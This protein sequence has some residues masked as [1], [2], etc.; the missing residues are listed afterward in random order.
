MKDVELNLS[1]YSKCLCPV[2]PVQA[3]STCI[4]GKNEGWREVR[5]SAGRV[6]RQYPDHPEV[7]DMD[8][9]ELQKSE[10]G[11]DQRFS[12]PAPEEMIE[13]Y[14]CK[15]VGKSNCNDLDV[16]QPCQC[17]TCAVW[18]SHD[19]GGYYYCTSGSTQ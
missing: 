7:Y 19:L 18:A 13:L 9:G 3:K 16:G 1:N 11:K 14:C 15:L 6:L 5:K 4:A 2:C 12:K 17:P 8:L 10:T